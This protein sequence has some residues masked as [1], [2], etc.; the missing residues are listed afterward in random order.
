ML[1]VQ[2][3]PEIEERLEALAKRTGKTTTDFVREAILDQIDD[4]EDYHLAEQRSK[5]I[6]EG[7]SDTV[8]LTELLKQHGM[9]N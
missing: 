8:P 6:D 5:D 3:P 1:D 9:D 2:L 4:L 7:R